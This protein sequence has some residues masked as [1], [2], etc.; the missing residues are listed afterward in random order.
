MKPIMKDISFDLSNYEFNNIFVKTSDKKPVHVSV[1]ESNKG[2]V[3]IT[4]NSFETVKSYLENPRHNTYLLLS[5]NLKNNNE[6]KNIKDSKIDI[7]YLNGEVPNAICSDQELFFPLVN[8]ISKSE[9]VM[10]SYRALFR[11]LYVDAK[12]KEI[13]IEQDVFRPDDSDTLKY[14]EKIDDLYTDL[15]EHSLITNNGLKGKVR[16]SNKISTFNSN[17]EYFLDT[18]A[19]DPAIAFDTEKTQVMFFHNSS[20]FKLKILNTPEFKRFDVYAF[21]PSIKAKSLINETA[22]D[23]NNDQIEIKNEIALDPVVRKEDLLFLNNKEQIDASINET[24]KKL[25]KKYQGKALRLKTSVVFQPMRLS[26]VKDS[27]REIKLTDIVSD[28]K[29]INGLEKTV[30]SVYSV[31]SKKK[32]IVLVADE[33]ADSMNDINNVK[34]VVLP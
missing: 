10:T 19:L 15:K 16:Y 17:S 5:G 26:D 2:P 22:F 9:E 11:Y 14:Y 21:H 28:K 33:I 30:Q 13:E 23:K 1:I 12:R 29:V 25:E 7:A 4:A 27:L 18:P 32:G 8:I 20:A 3:F 34:S 31:K 24:H 6:L